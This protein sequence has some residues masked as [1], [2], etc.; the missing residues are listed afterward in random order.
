VHCHQHLQQSIALEVA[1][2]AYQ[3]PAPALLYRCSAVPARSKR[4]QCLL[5]LLLCKH[6]ALRTSPGAG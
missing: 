3:R 1:L 2:V 6:A 5:S 4:V